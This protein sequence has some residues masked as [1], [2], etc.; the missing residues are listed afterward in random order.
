MRVF[1]V[2]LVSTFSFI[3]VGCDFYTM[4]FIKKSLEEDFGYVDMFSR[5]Y[6]LKGDSISDVPI[7]DEEKIL[8]EFVEDKIRLLE[9][10]RNMF[11][12]SKEKPVSVTSI[13]STKGQKFTIQLPS[14]DGIW[15]VK[16]YPL[17]VAFLD[18]TSRVRDNVFIFTTRDY[19]KDNIIFQLFSSNG[20]V[21]KTLE[22]EVTSVEAF[23]DK[24]TNSQGVISITNGGIMFGTSRKANLSGDSN[25]GKS[26]NYSFS[27]TND[28]GNILLANSASYDITDN[29]R[30]S[31][32]QSTE[33]GPPSNVGKL[34]L[35]FLVGDEEK[36]FE[37]ID[38]IASKYG[39]YRAIKEIENLES[40]VSRDDLPKLKLKKMEFLGR[41]NKFSDAIKEGEEFADK[42]SIIKL[43]TGI[44]FGKSK[45][46]SMADKNIRE[47]LA[48]ITN[49][50]ELSF[51]LREILAYYSSVPEPPTR[52]MI[53]I[54]LQRN[55]IILKDFKREY[56]ENLV[57]LGEL[58]E[59][60]GEVYKAMSIYENVCNS[61]VGED[62]KNFASSKKD[63]LNK[64]INFR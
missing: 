41:L 37:N 34:D 9:D 49:P 36:F 12:G 8:P 33:L 57:A 1:I 32:E 5:K 4:Y 24:A 21:I 45:N 38:N 54:I 27:S 14:E 13:F 59:R 2:I 52:E 63:R 46:Y 47:S 28:F 20:T 22:Y 18:G 55:E 6:Q 11:P 30:E 64:L 61:D 26:N 16:K 56:Y 40:N 51:A 53:N 10:E 25:A 29:E 3:L 39:Y 60:I 7:S 44:F 19:G 62:I 31:T 15:L 17:K 35:K 23:S 58:F 48:R 50:R 42:D 43:Y